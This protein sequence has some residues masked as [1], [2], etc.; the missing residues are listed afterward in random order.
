MFPKVAPVYYETVSVPNL[1][2]IIIFHAPPINSVFSNNS[3]G[4]KKKKKEFFLC[5]QIKVACQG[6]MKGRRREA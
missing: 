4:R 1:S 3:K 6:G 5:K 2:A